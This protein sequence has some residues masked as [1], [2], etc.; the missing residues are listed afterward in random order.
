MNDSKNPPDTSVEDL[1]LV[2]FVA[3]AQH[4]RQKPTFEVG[5]SIQ[6]PTSD[7]KCHIDHE[8]PWVVIRHPFHDPFTLERVC[9]KRRLKSPSS[10]V[11]TASRL[12]N[13]TPLGHDMLRSI[14]KL[15]GLVAS[16][17]RFLEK[18]HLMRRSWIFVQS[19]HVSL[20]CPFQWE[21]PSV[22]T[23]CSVFA[24]MFDLKGV[25]LADTTSLKLWVHSFA[26]T[27]L[28][29]KHVTWFTSSDPQVLLIIEA[30]FFEQVYVPMDTHRLDFIRWEFWSSFQILDMAWSDLSGI[31][32]L[33]S[34]WLSRADQSVQLQKKS[35][36]PFFVFQNC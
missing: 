16:P 35:A 9:V 30:P 32:P 28:G 5:G 15:P 1:L 19:P 11:S 20:A 2:T 3:A 33:P 18:L 27:R 24:D 29:Q 7:Q 8:T 31:Q 21:K 4:L 34:F 17:H 12:H 10:T 14:W 6:L 36:S 26:S 25:L 13:G 23:V 22:K